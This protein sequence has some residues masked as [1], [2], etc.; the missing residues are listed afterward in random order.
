M[1]NKLTLDFDE[2]YGKL[3]FEYEDKVPEIQN[4]SKMISWSLFETE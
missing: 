3:A 2:F 1:G 4:E